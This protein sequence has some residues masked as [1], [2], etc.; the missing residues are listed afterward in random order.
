MINNFNKV[1]LFFAFMLNSLAAYSQVAILEYSKGLTSN[2]HQSEIENILCQDLR[3]S[4]FL[5]RDFYSYHFLKVRS[6]LEKIRPRVV[7]MSFTLQHANKSDITFYVK[8]G[9]YDLAAERYNEREERINKNIESIKDLITTNPETLYTIA[10]GNGM[11]LS[12][13]MAFLE[14]EGVVLGGKNKLY[15]AVFQYPNTIKVA[16]A[17]TSSIS[18]SDLNNYSIANYSNYSV[19]FVDLLAPVPLASDGTT[20]DGTS[21][22]APFVAKLTDEL[23]QMDDEGS[24]TAADLK[25]ILMK[26]CFVKNIDKALAY[27][28]AAGDKTSGIVNDSIAKQDLILVRSG[29]IIIPEVARLCMKNYL[30]GAPSISEACL[31]GHREALGDLA[32]EAK[33]LK[34][35]WRARKL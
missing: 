4:S 16:A 31:A 1:F 8:N 6:K 2:N 29:G 33:K 25:E 23:I 17:N 34:L 15:P 20:L 26:S 3:C 32:N 35:F 7:N 5:L 22:A 24:I 18:N 10:A 21:F 19:E 28:Q 27:E 12:S 9:R 14:T 11:F 30:E 13:H